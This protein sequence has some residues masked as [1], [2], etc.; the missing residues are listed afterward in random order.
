MRKSKISPSKV[1][2]NEEPKST[3][4]RNNNQNIQSRNDNTLIGKNFNNN[5][6]GLLVGTSNSKYVS[7]KYI[8]GNN[9]C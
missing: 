7:A 6:L 1:N 3:S 9:M 4:N 5:A 2:S 8:A